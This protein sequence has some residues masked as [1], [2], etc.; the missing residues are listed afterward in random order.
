MSY[1]TLSLIPTAV[2]RPRRT[3]SL[4]HALNELPEAQADLPLLSPD[5][6]HQLKLY[7]SYCL[8]PALQQES[9]AM[10]LSP[11]DLLLQSRRQGL[12]GLAELEMLFSLW[13]GQRQARQKCRE[14]RQHLSQSR[15]QSIPSMRS[16]LLYLVSAR[17]QLENGYSDC[18]ELASLLD[19]LERHGLPPDSLQALES[20]YIEVLIELSHLQAELDPHWLSIA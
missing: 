2:S 20:E 5:F 3:Q 19:Q 16:E 10:L 13:Q 15:D 14:L 17:T 1:H 12:A 9:E 7:L 4:R 8:T 6:A 18:D 11:L